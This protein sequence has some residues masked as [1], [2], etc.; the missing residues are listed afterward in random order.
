MKTICI[1]SWNSEHIVAFARTIIN[2]I[3]IEC[4]VKRSACHI[5]CHL[6]KGQF[7]NAPIVFNV[8]SFERLTPKLLDVRESVLVKQRPILQLHTSVYSR[9][10]RQ[11][12]K[13]CLSERSKWKITILVRELHQNKRLL[14][15]D[16]SK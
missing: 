10:V 9:S 5:Y 6:S 11:N 8:N 4:F 12:D 3:S 15:N 16:R 2:S 14:N 13:E 7:F 1:V